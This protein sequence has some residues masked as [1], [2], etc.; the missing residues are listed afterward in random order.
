MKAH[1]L[2][3]VRLL[4]ALVAAVAAG[5]APNGPCHADDRPPTEAA[6]PLDP[7]GAIH[8]PIGIANTVDSLK[9]FVEAEGSF[10]PG[11]ASC[12]IYFWVFDPD[13]GRLTA[14]TMEG[15]KCEHG[16]EG[17]GFLIPWSA[18]EAAG[19]RVR[20]EV[21]HVR[22]PSPAG[23]VHVVAARACL[24][25]PGKERRKLLLFAV[26]RPLGPAG[27]PV[28]RIAVASDGTAL[29]VD[30][31]PALVGQQKPTAAGVLPTDAIAEW[32]TQGKLP[33]E[34]AAASATGDGSGGMGFEVTLAAGETKTLG[35]VC[36]VLP[37][38]RAAGHQWDR[39]SGWAQLDLAQPN[40]PEGGLL[41]PDPGLDYYRGLSTESLF[42]EA[43][44]YWKDLVGRATIDLPDPRWAECFA[45]IAGH[46]AMAMNEG[47]PDVAVVN[48]NVFN[49]DGVYVA[50][51]LQESAHPELAAQAIEYFLAHPFNGRVQ[52]EADNPGQVL[53][54]I[55]QHWLFTR[56]RAWLARVY[57]PAAKLAAMIRYYRTAPPPH[58]VKATSLEFGEA[59]PPDRPDE[60]PAD[61]RQVLR[62]GSCDGHHPEYTEAF[63]VAGLRA[64]A[65]LAKAA[66]NES[67]AQTWEKLAAALAASYDRRF[68]GKLPAGYGSYSVLWPCRLYPLES[69]PAVE[70]FRSV[71]RRVPDGWRYF[72]LATAHQGLLAGNREAG[73]GTLA[74]HLDHPQMR[75]WYAF[76]EGGGS[77]PGGW[78]FARTR[79]KAGV[80]MPH[81]WAIAEMFLLL[82][83]SLL[84]EDGPKLVLLA[85]IPEAWFT[86]KGPWSLENL[87]THFG[88]LSL[89]CVPNQGGAIVRLGG[90]ARPPEGFALR[91]PAALRAKVSI[92]GRAMGRRA[93]GDV[94]IPP[95][96][97]T[98]LLR[99]ESP[100]TRSAPVAPPSPSTAAAP[101]FPEGRNLRRG[102]ARPRL[103]HH[104]HLGVDRDRL[105]P[106]VAQKL[107]DVPDGHW[108]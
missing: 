65:M 29:L 59:L 91:L 8:V 67:D 82:R 32:A 20:T 92:E 95:G 108:P 61:R 69:G 89:A 35:F 96:T 28:R 81:G 77:G 74:A 12:G 38:R 58:Y 14:P 57:P 51:I 68:G 53:W 71:G 40:P 106:H 3:R 66:G 11:F 6:A 36:P 7:R 88:N 97:K 63:D 31:R 13:G 18:W 56:D 105:Q 60:K 93:N 21:C 24:T 9:T 79:W 26:L 86:P 80:A 87:P 25:N 34:K 48:Y 2:P 83:D 78:R 39:T 75:G 46:A 90:T 103:P 16:L 41:Q 62:P 104:G 1:C 45:A 19:V 98:V 107:L 54:I 27:G 101:S 5:M 42:A 22:R 10:S 30:G 70:Q 84:H 37:G 43:A 64:A 100:A 15:L 4:L 52:C 73:H 102:P 50:N 44:A 17:R 49:R 23:E 85:G 76:D 33:P 72:S 99:W 94:L 55:G 47:A